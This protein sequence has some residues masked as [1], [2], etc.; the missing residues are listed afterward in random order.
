MQKLTFWIAV[1]ALALAAVSLFR[2]VDIG[3]PRGHEPSSST[4]QRQ[5]PPLVF[6]STAT[7]D[8]SISST[9]AGRQVM[10]TVSGQGFTFD[11]AM[12]PIVGGKVK[13][14]GSGMHYEFNAYPDQPVPATFTGVGP[15]K[16]TMF[17]GEVQVDVLRFSQPGGPGTSIHFTAA[18][19]DPNGAYVEF[20][21]VFV[22]DRDNKAFPFRVLFG[23]VGA[24]GGNVLPGGVGPLTEL[25]S[26]SVRL[27]TTGAAAPVITALYENEEDVRPL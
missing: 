27:G 13:L 8:C 17:K 10:T 9:S 11:A 3:F 7:L 5:Y 23:T 14:Q 16:I 1:V 2:P 12:K 15:G 20:T 25:R 19:M 26:K 4:A 6:S 22:R 18:D 21:G 24:G